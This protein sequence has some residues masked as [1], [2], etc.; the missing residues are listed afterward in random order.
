MAL[1]SRKEKTKEMVRTSGH[2]DEAW[3]TVVGEEHKDVVI[4]TAVDHTA[5]AD[6][7]HGRG[8]A[9]QNVQEVLGS[10][11]LTGVIL[12]HIGVHVG[13]VGLVDDVAVNKY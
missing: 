6:A 8:V 4:D 5:A 1:V 2:G 3:A 10:H 12:R 7:L 13:T 11:S 9:G